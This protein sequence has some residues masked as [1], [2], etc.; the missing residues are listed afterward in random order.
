[1]RMRG[2]IASFWLAFL[3]AGAAIAALLVRDPGDIS[4]WPRISLTILPAWWLVYAFGGP[5]SFVG[6]RWWYQGPVTFVVALAMWW[7]VLEG[8]R[9]L[10][11]VR[12]R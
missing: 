12:R 2:R 3:I 9:R 10:W 7:A 11:N 5:H 8:W 4:E 1:M 6:G